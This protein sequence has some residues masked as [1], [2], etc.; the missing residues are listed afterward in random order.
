MPRD[1]HTVGLI[2]SG[3]GRSLSPALH[4]REGR[5]RTASLPLPAARHRR[6]STPAEVGDLLEPRGAPA[7]PASTSPTPA[8]SSSLV[9]S[10]PSPR[11]P[12]RSARSTPSSSTASG[13]VGHN[14]DVTGFAALR[15]RTARRAQ[16]DRCRA[17]RRRRSRGGRRPR[18]A[19]PGRRAPHGP[20][21][22]TPRRGLAGAAPSGRDAPTPADRRRW[23]LAVR[24]RSRARHAHRMAAHPG[25]PLARDAAAPRP[26]GRRRR[27]PAAGNRTAAHRP[28]TRLPHPRRRRHGRL[29]GRR[30]LRLFTGRSP[31]A[32]GCSPTSQDARLRKR[33][34]VD[35]HRL[36]QRHARA[37]ARRDRGRA[38]FDGVEI[39][40]N[41]LLALARSPP[42]SPRPRRRP[43]PRDRPLP[44]VPRLRGAAAGRS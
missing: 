41:D 11:R 10:T 12:R 38:G 16:L 44:A 35:R 24:R 17:A 39:F 31:T 1:H 3:I 33:T 2:G 21:R 26:V 6:R 34:R 27:L 36:P 22:A 25:L 13:A 42:R 9:T 8:S 29:P 4:E 14:T 7:S 40:E 18:A 30:R 19:R 43:R 28:R 32:H 37:E 23:T 5:P 20:R 15:P